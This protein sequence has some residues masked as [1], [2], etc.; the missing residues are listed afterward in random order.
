MVED[1]KPEITAHTYYH[2]IYDK[3]G[4]NTQWRKDR[5]LQ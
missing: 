1:R 4:K 5:S 2:L 3:G